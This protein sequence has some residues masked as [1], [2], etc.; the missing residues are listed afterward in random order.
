[1]KPDLQLFFHVLGA[2]GLFGTTGTVA[3]LAFAARRHPGQPRLAAAALWTLLV[4][5]IPAWVLMFAFGN[6]T[7]SKLSAYLTPDPAWLKI[8]SGI[9][10]AGIVFLLVSAGLAYSWTR[11]PAAERVPLALGLL[12]TAYLAALGVAWWVMSAKV[13]S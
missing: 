12:S 9:A 6:W 8:G 2:I 11:R 3:I 1:V 13:P 10:S 7:K 5:A 4:G